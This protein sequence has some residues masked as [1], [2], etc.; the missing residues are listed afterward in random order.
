MS[1]EQLALIM[2]YLWKQGVDKRRIKKAV[3]IWWKI[4][5]SK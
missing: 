1:D 3:D 4:K 5:E 2:E